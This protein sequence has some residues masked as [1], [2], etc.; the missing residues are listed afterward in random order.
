LHEKE[1]MKEKKTQYLT[2]D[3]EYEGIRHRA[4]TK[5]EDGRNNV[6]MLYDDH[7]LEIIWLKRIRHKGMY[8]VINITIKDDWNDMASLGVVTASPW[9]C[10][11]DKSHRLVVAELE[12][13][14]WSYID[15]ENAANYTNKN[16]YYR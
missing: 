11:Y 2:Y 9:V 13:D 10:V 16:V 15:S 6:V 3:F 7:N 12:P 1:M 4:S 5:L 8:M 14:K